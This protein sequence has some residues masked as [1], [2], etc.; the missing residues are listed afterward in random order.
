M[1][2][3]NSS[4]T[5]CILHQSVG[6]SSNQKNKS[7]RYPWDKLWSNGAQWPYVYICKALDASLFLF[8][9][10]PHTNDKTRDYI[11]DILCLVVSFMISIIVC[12][13]CFSICQG[14][15]H[16]NHYTMPVNMCHWAIL[17]KWVML[18]IEFTQ[19]TQKL[20]NIWREFVH[21]GVIPGKIKHIWLNVLNADIMLCS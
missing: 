8:H 4:S 18:T 14:F 13:N 5:V 7:L 11:Y 1:K 20:V 10:P 21:T 19:I 2:T 12:E 6:S 17:T 15:W 3:F 16:T 9:T